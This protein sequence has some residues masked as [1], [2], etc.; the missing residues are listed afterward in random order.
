MVSIRTILIFFAFFYVFLCISPFTMSGG[1]G[2][3]SVK[4][5]T[6]VVDVKD[7]KTVKAQSVVDEL[8]EEYGSDQIL[9][10]VPRSGNLYEITL[11][12]KEVPQ[13]W[14]YRKNYWTSF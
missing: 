8:V 12:D 3:S 7:N 6:L 13:L 14:Q 11:K 10:V 9:A 1:R 2:R 4:E 5:L